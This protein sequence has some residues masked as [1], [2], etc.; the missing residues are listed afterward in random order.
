MRLSPLRL[1]DVKPFVSLLRLT[2]RSDFS[3][4]L[5]RDSEPNLERDFCE[6]VVDLGL[7]DSVNRL[8]TGFV[9]IEMFMANN[10]SAF[11]ASHG[12]S[13]N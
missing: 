6:R 2:L 9:S 13:W 1:R 10:N 11:N 4:K 3:F 7:S 8:R 12:D 5:L